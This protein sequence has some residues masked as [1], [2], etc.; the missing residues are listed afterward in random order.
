VTCCSANSSTASVGPESGAISS[1]RFLPFRK[2]EQKMDSRDPAQ[3]DKPIVSY[4]CGSFL[5]VVM[6]GKGWH[7]SEVQEEKIYP[8]SIRQPAS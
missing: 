2:T 1:G 4:G 7:V 3:M 8:T 5:A 6:D